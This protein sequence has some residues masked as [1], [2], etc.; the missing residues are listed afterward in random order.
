MTNGEKL[1]NVLAN[2]RTQSG[3][4][5]TKAEWVVTADKFLDSLKPAKAPRRANVLGKGLTDEQW[6]AELVKDPDLAGVDI[7][8]E[9][10]K[11]RLWTKGKNGQLPSRKRILNWLIRAEP[12]APEFKAAPV[13]L[14]TEPPE[15]RGT[16]QEMYPNTPFA[17]YVRDGVAW[18]E[19]SREMRAKITR[20]L[21]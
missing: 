18:S 20:R 4:K 1:F 3:G 21:P 10:R 19:L 11:C 6:F 9:A 15:W 5:L 16:V 8:D 17:D 7:P 14:E 2:A 13:D 12:K